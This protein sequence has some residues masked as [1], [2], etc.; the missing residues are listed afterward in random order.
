MYT[1]MSKPVGELFAQLRQRAEA[2]RYCVREL[3]KICGISPRHFERV[4]KKRFQTTPK[5]WIFAYRMTRAAELLQKGSA[6]KD[7]AYRLYYRDTSQFSRAFKKFHGCKPS[8]YRNLQTCP[9]Q[10]EPLDYEDPQMLKTT[11]RSFPL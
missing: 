8:E 9:V 2:S 11:A 7:V 4:F 1:L 10:T 3:A 5:K 6:I